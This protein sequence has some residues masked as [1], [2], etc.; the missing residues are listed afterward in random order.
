MGEPERS[1]DGRWIIV[2]GRRW[3][4]TDPSIPDSLRRQLVNELMAAR[5]AIRAARGDIEAAGAARRRVR[6]AKIALG[7]RGPRWWETA[8][9]PG[10][11]ERATASIRA[12]LRNRAP[13]ATI[14]PS[15]AARA[16]FSPRW[17]AS[18]DDVRRWAE[19]MAAAGE[20]TILRKGEAQDAARSSSG[21][22]RLGRGPRLDAAPGEGP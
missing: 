19:E 3:R 15:E 13:E 21:P 2:D 7:E 1:D 12:L 14:C 22:V 8:D 16:A 11:R 9:E 6:D 10:R 18:M 20:I 17:R 4:A 5:R